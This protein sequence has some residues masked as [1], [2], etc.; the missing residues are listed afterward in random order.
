[1]HSTTCE[2]QTFSAQSTFDECFKDL[3]VECE[4]VENL[5]SNTDFVCHEV[6]ILSNNNKQVIYSNNAIGPRKNIRLKFTFDEC[7][8]N[9]LRHIPMEQYWQ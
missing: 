9:Q 3:C 7:D 1:M 6:N 4:F 2:L 5:C 8:F